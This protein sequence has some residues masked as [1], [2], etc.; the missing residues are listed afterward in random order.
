MCKRGKTK[1]APKIGAFLQLFEKIPVFRALLALSSGFR[2]GILDALADAGSLAGAAAQ[3]IE[4]GAAHLALA[5][6]DDRVDQRGID[7]EDALDAFA[8]GELAHR[9]G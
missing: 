4:R 2:T 8:I 3:V 5:D 1:K 6:H 9:E 7:R